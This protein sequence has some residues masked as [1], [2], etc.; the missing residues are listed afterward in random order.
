MGRSRGHVQEGLQ[1]CLCVNH[2]GIP[3]F[4]TTSNSALKTP[5]NT[6]EDPDDS[7]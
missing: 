3:L 4:L 7:E 2:C 1:E 5:E 6:E